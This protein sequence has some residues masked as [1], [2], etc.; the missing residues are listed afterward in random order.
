MNTDRQYPTSRPSWAS[1]PLRATSAPGAPGD[2]EARKELLAT[3][4]ASR[5]LGPDMDHTL[6][7]RYLERLNQRQT[8]SAQWQGR[9]R[10][11]TAANLRRFW[12]LLVIPA[13]L[14]A[15]LLLMAFMAAVALHGGPPDGGFMHHASQA[16]N[17]GFT[18]G[19]RAN[20]QG[21]YA[22]HGDGFFPLFGLFFWALPVL[23][24]ILFLR[25]RAAMRRARYGA[26]AGAGPSALGGARPYQSQPLPAARADEPYAQYAPYER[27]EPYQP[28]QPFDYTTA[29]IPTTT[30]SSI[31]PAPPTRVIVEADSQPAQPGAAAP[32]QPHAGS[33]EHAPAASEM[34][35]DMADATPANEQ[36]PT[37]PRPPTPPT[38]PLSNLAG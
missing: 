2:D 23:A 29:S 30:T 33:T 16:G 26:V 31:P 1:Q 11:L 6:A 28:Y 4:A 8:R 10:R 34:G 18:D 5:D 15:G 14:L 20:G 36:A 32:D 35:S 38:G 12:P 37:S 25:R 24:L 19:A 21:M 7:A 9:S 27:Y 13:V 22:D 17:G 3:L